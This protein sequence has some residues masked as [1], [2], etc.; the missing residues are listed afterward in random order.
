MIS[1]FEHDLDNK[2]FSLKDQGKG[3]EIDTLEN[4][5]KICFKIIMNAEGP[6]R[7]NLYD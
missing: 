7:G 6:I 1:H 5:T 3:D 2:T 4:R